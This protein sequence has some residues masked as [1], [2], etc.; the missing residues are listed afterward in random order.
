MEPHLS[1][2]R[3]VWQISRRGLSRLE[4]DTTYFVTMQRLDWTWHIVVKTGIPWNNEAI[5][6]NMRSINSD[7]ENVTT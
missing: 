4:Q 5:C 7:E 1:G 6:A 3:L 2:F